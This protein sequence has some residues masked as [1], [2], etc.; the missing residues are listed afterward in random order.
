M[1]KTI[2]SVL[3]FSSLLSPAPSEAFTAYGT[4]KVSHVKSEVTTDFGPFNELMIEQALA[5]ALQMPVFETSLETAVDSWIRPF[6]PTTWLGDEE[7]V[8]GLK[9]VV[10]DGN[11]PRK[12]ECRLSFDPTR[13]ENYTFVVKDCTSSSTTIDPFVMSAKLVFG[14]I[15]KP[16]NDESRVD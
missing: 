1:K 4:T 14:K 12:M 9:F 16:S 8:F 2:F 13:N 6:Y 15:K 7:R 10:V 11:F 3:V 5:R